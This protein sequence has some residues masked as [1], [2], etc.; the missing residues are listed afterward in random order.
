[1]KR[2]AYVGVYPPGVIEWRL[3][4][5]L[6]S[7][8]NLIGRQIMLKLSDEFNLIHIINYEHAR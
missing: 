5:N 8:A 6:H 4:W 1:M 2:V 7:A 3:A